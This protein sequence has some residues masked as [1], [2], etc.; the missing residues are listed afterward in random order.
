MGAAPRSQSIPSCG[1][2][3]YHQCSAPVLA[4]NTSTESVKRFDPGRSWGEKSGTGFPTGTNSSPVTGSNANED[5]VPPPPCSAH[6]VFFQVSAPC[7][8]PVG[9]VLNLQI[10]RPG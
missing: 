2:S 9:I 7:S 5:Q 10:S 1:T 6:V 3:W 4:S 8:V